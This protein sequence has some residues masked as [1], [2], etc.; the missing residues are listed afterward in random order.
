MKSEVT[1]SILV[2]FKLC[3]RVIETNFENTQIIIFPYAPTSY[4]LYLWFLRTIENSFGYRIEKYKNYFRNRSATDEYSEHINLQ[5]DLVLFK[6]RHL[7]SRIFLVWLAKLFETGIHFW[8]VNVW[9]EHQKFSWIRAARKYG[10]FG[11]LPFIFRR[12]DNPFRGDEVDFIHQHRIVPTNFL[13]IP[14]PLEWITRAASAQV[15]NRQSV[16]G[17]HHNDPISKISRYQTILHQLLG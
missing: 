3:I 16:D 1:L 12:L 13:E 5:E 2:T 15:L 17:G 8:L 7:G 14:G 4:I 6:L 11:N 9:P 10:D